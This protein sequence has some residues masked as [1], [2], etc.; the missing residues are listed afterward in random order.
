MARLP[1]VMEEIVRTFENPLE[2]DPSLVA[3]CY[4]RPEY[5]N[6]MNGLQEMAKRDMEG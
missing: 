2:A 6:T 3:Y 5:R 4:F 1:K